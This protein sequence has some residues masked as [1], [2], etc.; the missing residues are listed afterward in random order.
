MVT[1]IDNKKPHEAEPLFNLLVKEGHR[2]SL[3]TYTTLVTAMIDQRKFKSIPSLISKVEKD[4]LKPDSIFLNAIINAFSE[5]GKIDEAIKIF[6]K[7]KESGCR[8]TTST[9]NTLIKGY[10]IVGKPEESQKLFDMMSREGSA[11]PTQKT[12]NILIKAWCDKL[13]LV[14]VWNVLQK[15]HASGIEPDVVTYNTIARAYTKNGETKRGEELVLEMQK[16][17]RPNEHTWAIILAG[18]CK[19]GNMNDALRCVTEMKVVGIRPNIVVFNTLVKGF[20]EVQDIVG[21]DEVSN[22][23]YISF[24]LPISE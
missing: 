16:R 10:G 17:L 2:P 15:M 23:I 22:S 21:V 6:R 5:A 3:V 24:F 8:P 11:R 12:F 9:F 7:M 20:L 18:Y 1:L 13:N 4:G 14:E 19:E